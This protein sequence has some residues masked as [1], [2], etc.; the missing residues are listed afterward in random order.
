M[1]ALRSKRAPAR[2]ARVPMSL[3][4]TCFWSGI[5][6]NRGC[7]VAA[8]GARCKRVSSRVY[9]LELCGGFVY[10]GKSTDI[11]RRVEEHM[12]GDG[13]WFT[14]AYRPTGRLLRRLGDLEGEG[15]GPERDETLRQMDA[16][17]CQRVRGWKYTQKALSAA[18]VREIEANIRE[19]KDLCRRCG[20]K[21]H[22]WGNC[23]YRTD[24]HGKGL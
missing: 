11:K 6:A 12:R 5:I 8:P 14:R 24:R 17:G 10:V 13:A 22:F 9:V 20:R 18:D 1:I 19:M 21:G 7:T 2:T 3:I 15:D 4:P 23:A 16:K